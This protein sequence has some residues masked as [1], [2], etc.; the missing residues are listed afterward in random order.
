MSKL[1]FEL[2]KRLKAVPSLSIDL[3]AAATFLEARDGFSQAFREASGLTMK[4]PLEGFDG[5]SVS[6]GKKGGESLAASTGLLV[7]ELSSRNLKPAVTRYALRV[8]NIFS[9]R[10]S[11]QPVRTKTPTECRDAFIKVSKGLGPPKS[12]YTDED[13]SFQNEFA[14]LLREEHIEHRITRSH[15][16][17]FEMLIGTLK[18]LVFEGRKEVMNSSRGRISSL[19]W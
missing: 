15:A 8:V 13:G 1:T 7:V 4:R 18:R 12:T 2:N 19:W 10:V 9:K 14:D 6:T 3:G 17:F 11:I 16:P 5:L